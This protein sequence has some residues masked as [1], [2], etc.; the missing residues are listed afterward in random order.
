MKP[1]MIPSN[2]K[3]A[4][5]IINGKRS[6]RTGMAILT[7]GNTK[8]EIAVIE[9]TMTIAADTIPASTAAVP[10]TKVPT[11]DTACPTA[12]GIRMPASRKISK[13]TSITTAGNGTPSRCAIKFVNKSEGIIS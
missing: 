4:A 5:N 10:T 9:T 8:F 2:P 1:A 7:E 3:E 12:F 13:V 6:M 11:M